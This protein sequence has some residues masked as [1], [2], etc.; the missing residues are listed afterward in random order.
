ML[1]Q[2]VFL[3][4]LESSL[5]TTRRRRRRGAWAWFHDVCKTCSAKV[6]EY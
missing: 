4:F 6:L 5:S 1:L 2:I 3:V